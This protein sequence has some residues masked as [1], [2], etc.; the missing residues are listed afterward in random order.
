MDRDSTCFLLTIIKDGDINIFS[1]RDDEGPRRVMIFQNKDDAERYVIM[2][3]QDEEYVIGESLVMDITE[4]ALGDAI[5]I[6]SEKGHDYILVKDT[7]LFI[8]P[9]A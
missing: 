5:D 7:D 2:M 4:V 6:L 3:E 9:L 1:I 8:P